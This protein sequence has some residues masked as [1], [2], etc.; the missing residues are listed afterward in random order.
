M[1]AFI[2]DIRAVADLRWVGWSGAVADYWQ[3]EGRR[4]G[5]GFYVAPDPRM[6]IFL[7]AAPGIGLSARAERPGRARLAFIPAGVPVWSTVHLDGVFSHLDLHFSASA[8]PQ[9]RDAPFALP[10]AAVLLDRHEGIERLAA[11]IVQEV[12]R[13][14]C[15]PLLLNGL[16]M[17]M[18]AYFRQASEATAPAEVSAGGLTPRQQSRVMK[19]IEDGLHRRITV[20]E[21]AEET[22][23]SESWF[24]RAYRTTMG[25]TPARTITRLR[26][27]QAKALLREGRGS[28][29]EI[30]AATG[31]ADQAH[32]TRVFRTHTGTT[33]AVWRG[34]MSV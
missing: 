6:V 17:A 34:L 20:A 30:A 28:I 27:E 9:Q 10:A 15:D 26:L 24:A 32:F 14:G 23:L 31:F 25:E 5:R 8:L 2:E 19:I 12:C 33:P 4:G 29:V 13:N 18:V 21:L 1:S 22:G 7:E 11:L 16:L 3:V